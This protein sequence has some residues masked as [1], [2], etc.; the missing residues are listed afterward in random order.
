MGPAMPTYSL[1]VPAYNEEAVVAE[2]VARLR[3]LM[4]EL[5]GDAEAILVDDGSRDRTYELMAEATAGD[6]RFRLVSL[7]RNFGH[8]IALTAGLDHAAGDAVIVHRRRPAGPAGSRARAGQALARGLRRRLC[9]ARGAQGRD[10]L[11]A[12]RPRPGSTA[13][14]TVSPMCTCRSTSATS[15]SSTAARSRSAITCARATALYA[16]CSRGSA[17]AD[18]RRVRAAGALRR[19][20]QVPAP[21]NVPLRGLGRGHSFSSAPLHAALN[22]GFLVSGL[23]L[24]ARR[25]APRRSSSSASTTCRAGRRSWWS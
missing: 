18:G 11:Q 20:D 7:S 24:R 10:A 22:L 3:T 15:A 6:P 4:D 8:Q 12:G 16:A 2:L 21:G 17:A 19:R 23:E 9:G 25:L 13:P 14:S 5:D 1:V